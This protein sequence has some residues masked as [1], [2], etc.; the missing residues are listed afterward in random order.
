MQVIKYKN[1]N[2]RLTNIS[3]VLL[4]EEQNGFRT[5]RSC[6][7]DIFTIKE[8]IEKRREYNL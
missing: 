2:Q 1:Y 5:G 7:D 4:T 6:M 8:V 3:D